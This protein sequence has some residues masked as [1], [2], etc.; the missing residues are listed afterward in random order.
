LCRI[1]GFD[2]F[3][4]RSTGFLR[5]FGANWPLRCLSVDFDNIFY[6]CLPTLS[7]CDFVRSVF[8]FG[9]GVKDSTAITISRES[10][11]KCEL[12]S[13][14]LNEPNSPLTSRVSLRILYMPPVYAVI[15]FFSY[16][17]F[18][19]YT[20]YSLV[21]SGG[22]LW[23][24]SVYWVDMNLLPFQRMKWEY[25]LMFWIPSDLATGNHFKRLLVCKAYFKLF[26]TDRPCTV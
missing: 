11:G 24:F 20:Y 16:R 8:L 3:A 5:I 13:S 10:S 12:C 17:Y 18:R 15:S 21:E 23:L 2:S 22:P 7:V 26:Q 1:G 6:F 25:H 9:W 14:S 19:S 4:A